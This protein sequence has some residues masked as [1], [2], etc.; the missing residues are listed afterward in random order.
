MAADRIEIHAQLFYIHWNFPRRL[1]AI[2]MDQNPGFSRD[3][4]NVPDGLN[5]A[6][7]VIRVHYRNQN[8]FRTQRVLDIRGIDN[9]VRSHR[10]VAHF[11]ALALELPARIQHRRML[12]GCGDDVLF[13]SRMRS[14]RAQNRQI[15]SLRTAA[16]K[17]QILR[18]GMDQSGHLAARYF[19]FLPGILPMLM[20]T[21]RVSIHFK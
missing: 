19:Q 8:R 1:H 6:Q 18:V 17:H 5:G 3:R 7:F 4:R 11:H 20:N 2:N 12:N 9:T 14:H 10:N 21:G 15:V 16:Q 13:G